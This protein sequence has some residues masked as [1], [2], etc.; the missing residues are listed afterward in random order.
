MKIVRLRLKGRAYDIIIGSRIISRLPGLLNRLN[1]GR[2]AYVITNPFLKKKFGGGLKR[3]LENAG[4]SVRLKTVPDSEKAKSLK[5]ASLILADLAAYDRK[6]KIFII[7]L[8]GGVVG[9][10]SG[11]VASFYR[12]GI[13]YIQVPTTLLA[14]IDSSI[15]GKAAVDLPEG[16]NLVGAFYQP[17][18][19]LSDI[20]FLLSLNRRQIA[21]GMAEA[22]KYG[23]IKDKN[24]FEYL[25]KNT[26][27]PTEAALRYIVERCSR[28]KAGIVERDEKETRG[29]RTLLNFGHTIGHAI[30]SATGYARLNH[31]EAIAIGMLAAAGISLRLKMLSTPELKRIEALTKKA[32][33]P[34]KIRGVPLKAVIKAHYHDKKFRG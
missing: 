6:R 2:D 28:I 10:L 26:P 3:V 19:V 17:R 30:E 9:D 5:T 22:I 33:L 13:P 14:Q 20:R 21:S 18:L 34:V 25:E 4:Y 16:K 12:R 31:G 24:L 8:G 11:L 29:L 15:G 23:C 32:G 27:R 7:A 1:L